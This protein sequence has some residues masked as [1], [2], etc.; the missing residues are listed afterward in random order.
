MDRAI[1]VARRG[2]ARSLARDGWQWPSLCAAVLVAR[3]HLG[4]D[5]AAFARALGVPCTTVALL[6]GGGCAPLLAPPRLADVVPDI[7]WAALG[8]PVRARAPTSE[9]SGRHPAG[10][11]PGRVL[12]P[13]DDAC[14]GSNGGP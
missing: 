6:E 12:A 2:L 5:S 4:L 13:T 1:E 3:A 11:R 8:V 9:P 7:D 10:H 14:G